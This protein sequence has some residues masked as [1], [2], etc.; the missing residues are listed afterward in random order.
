MMNKPNFPER[1][2]MV[3]AMELLARAVND[4]A[5][6]ERWLVLGVA[7]GDID[8]DGAT[9][10]EDLEYYTE[11]DTFA[12]LMDTFLRVMSG[13]HRSGGLYFDNITSKEDNQS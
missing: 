3:R 10:D 13:A 5:V 7:D 6:F 8:P 11:D 2:K 12:E 9:S 4:E 1:I